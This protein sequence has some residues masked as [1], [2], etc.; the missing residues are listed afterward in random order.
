[1]SSIPGLDKKNSSQD[2]KSCVE[3]RHRGTIRGPR[4]VDRLVQRFSPQAF[5]L[6]VSRR[7]HISGNVS[8]VYLWKHLGQ[9]ID[10]IITG[11]RLRADMALRTSC[12][13]LRGP[14]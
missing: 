8:R 11:S 14:K 5:D 3:Y 10:R 13:S 1:M 2:S 4:R 7:A 6:G 9:H 12:G